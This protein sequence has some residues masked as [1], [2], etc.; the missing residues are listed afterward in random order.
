ML[1]VV[2]KEFKDHVGEM[3]N[4]KNAAREK[5]SNSSSNSTRWTTFEDDKD[6]DDDDENCHPNLFSAQQMKNQ[7]KLAPS[8]TDYSYSSSSYI[9]NINSNPFFHQQPRSELGF[10]QDQNPFWSPK[11]KQGGAFLP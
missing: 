9:S 3:E 8:K 6:D 1:D 2:K 7:T 11:K 4:K 5:H 10:Y